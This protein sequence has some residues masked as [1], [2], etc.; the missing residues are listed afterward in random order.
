MLACMQRLGWITEQLANY[1]NDTLGGLL[2][3]SFGN[4]TEMI[5]SGFALAKRS[6]TYLRVV[7]LSLLGSIISNLLLVR[8]HACTRQHACMCV[9]C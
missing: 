2:N 5:I 9:P 6:E 4:A 3:A 1:T 7:Q 8:H